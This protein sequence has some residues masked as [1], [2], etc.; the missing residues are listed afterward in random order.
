VTA[1]V[2]YAERP[3]VT[4]SHVVVVFS[5]WR[6]DP[7]HALCTAIGAAVAAEL[8]AN[9]PSPTGSSLIETLERCSER[10]DGEVLVIL[11]QFEE[12]FVYHP[13]ARP[14]DPFPMQLARAITDPNLRANFL[15]SIRDDALARLHLFKGLIPGLFEN[16]LQLDRLTREAGREAIVLPLEHYN[17]LVPETERVSIEPELV[18]GVLDEVTA[19]RVR[20]SQIGV[21]SVAAATPERRIEAPYL[22]LVME[23]LWNAERERGSST[24][25]LET[26]E[27][28][29]G[30]QEIVRGYLHGELLRLPPDQRETAAAIF[31]H[32]VTPSGTKIAHSPEDLAALS[33]RSVRDI[34]PM[35]QQLERARILR[36]EGSRYEIFHD[37]L[38]GA[39]LEWRSEYEADQR[40]DRERRR[41]RRLVAGLLGLL[42]VV[43]AVAALAVFS[44]LQ[45][46]EASKQRT[47]AQVRQLILAAD[48]Q[49]TVDPQVS[50]QLAVEAFTKA[51]SGDE[52]SARGAVLRALSGSR[53]SPVGAV[54]R[55][56]TNPTWTAAFSPDSRLVVTASDDWT[57]RVWDTRSGNE[58]AV[59]EHDSWVGDARFSP[60]GRRIVTASGAGDDT[61]RVWDAESGQQLAVLEHPRT[62]REVAFSPNGRW[63]ATANDDGVAR[64]WDWRRAKTVAVLKGHEGRVRE[65]AFSPDGARLAT[66]SDDGTARVWDW[67]TGDGLLLSG[68]EGR[69]YEVAFSSDGR[70]VV[71]ADDD[72]TARVWD[73]GTGAATAVLRG[74]KDTVFDAAFDPTG[75][76]VVTASGDGTARVWL[77]DGTPLAVLQGHQGS[78]RAATFTPDGARA[79][80]ASDDGTIRIWRPRGGPSV[81]VL[82]GHE[83]AINDVAVSPDGERLVTAGDDRTARVWQARSEPVLA[84]L[85]GHQSAV[86]VAVF[87]PDGARVVTASDDTTA[88]VWNWQRERAIAVLGGHAGALNDAV[89]LPEGGVVAAG[90]DGTPRLWRPQGGQAI[91]L[92]G[93]EGA[94]NDV[95]ASTDGRLVVT[96]SD[97]GTARVWD[98]QG[99][100]VAVLR[101]HD[102]QVLSAS[103][104]PDGTRVVTGTDDGTARVWDAGSGQELFAN[105]DFEDSVVKVAFSPNGE[106]VLAAAQ[107]AVELWRPAADRSISLQ[108]EGFVLD[109]AFDPDGQRVVTTSLVNARIWDAE[110]GDELAV[111][112]GHDGVVLSA[113]YSPD[114][115]RVATTSWDGTARIW[116]SESG[117]EIAVFRG[118]SGAVL[119]AAFS[120][121]G[122]DLVTAGADG[123]ARVFAC[124]VCG[125]NE[126]LLTLARSRIVDPLTAE[127][128]QRLG[129][130]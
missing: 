63:V 48:S 84:I 123:T 3:R 97:D 65:V 106:W 6:G 82:R 31:G 9:G 71:T 56:H 13:D 39:V 126:R 67:R 89:V 11:D 58:L 57:A 102:S 128:R 40:I 44:F 1:E 105:D 115:E 12:F 34:E 112:R 93:H 85:R 94:I 110:S 120:P 38:A 25:R 16:R 45:W 109:A 119:G 69:V 5:S 59:L 77:V 113:V 51:P 90:D 60:D 122:N 18:D 125:P 118:H 46:R 86:R 20:T 26:L 35:L 7:V 41:R 27:E 19:G 88:R 99:A 76:R 117:E 130:D 108:H 50:L 43:V 107:D 4:A 24:L 21:G 114:G 30:A 116:D 100:A 53:E 10:Y 8:E 66:A 36:H 74:H 2:K 62:V 121:D 127:D 47:V 33:G 111:L 78:V 15:V 32:L 29:G 95:A 37:V 91:V 124:E 22:Q 64:V 14:E 104:S 87:D 80:T 49:L 83:G 17:A 68:H 28:L 70:S 73:S 61:A 81:A 92:R 55:G 103:F 129:I 42:G 101:G 79:V 54:L 98:R 72:G 96:A 23:R 52:G 75:T